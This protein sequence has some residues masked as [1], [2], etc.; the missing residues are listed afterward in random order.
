MEADDLLAAVFPDRPPAPRTCAG[1]IEIPDHPLVAQTI[2]DCLI[3]AMDI[4]GLARC[5]RGIERGEIRVVARDT[6]E[7]SPLPHEILNAHPYAFLDDAPLEERRTQAVMARRWL[8]PETAADLGTLDAAAIRRVREEVWPA[9]RN[10]DELH[11]ALATLA[12]LADDE[13]RPEWRAY[14]DELGAG[15]TR[16]AVRPRDL[17]RRRAA[18]RVPRRFSRAHRSP[19]RSRR[20]RRTASRGRGTTRWSRS[21]AT[22]C[23]GSAR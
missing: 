6:T 4:D 8:D 15:A 19:P 5:S 17:G 21:F 20:R 1:D 18:A 2:D 9:A 3:E 23:R 13:L 12:F 10:A 22:A 7:P 14:A 16:D 11:D